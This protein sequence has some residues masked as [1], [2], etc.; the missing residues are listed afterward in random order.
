MAEDWARPFVHWDIQARDPERI[1][2]FYAKMFNWQIGD[3]P[4]MPIPAG[5]G[6]VDPEAMAGNIFRSDT[7]GFR[8]YIQVRDL[9]E[10]MQRARDLGGEATAE[11]FDVPGGP[12]IVAISDPEGNRLVLVQQ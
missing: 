7:S 9:R 8:L 10:S 5:I 4:L 6:G 3:A 2:G 11:P 1:K 12:T